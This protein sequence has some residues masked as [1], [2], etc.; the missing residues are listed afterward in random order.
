MSHFA[1]FHVLSIR[2]VALAGL[3]V[4]IAT[5]VSFADPPAQ[6]MGLGELPSG[7]FLSGATSVSADGSTVVGSS[8]VSALP[9]SPSN[10]GHAFRWQSGPMMDLGWGDCTEATGTS[11]YGDVVVGKTTLCGSAE[12]RG[13][14][15]DPNGVNHVIDIGKFT[16]LYDVSGDGVTSVGY[17]DFSISGGPTRALRMTYDA[18]GT[19]SYQNLGTLPGALSSRANGISLDGN[20]VVGSSTFP[21]ALPSAFRWTSTDGMVNL[22]PLGSSISSTAVAASSTGHS[23]VGYRR[24]ASMEREAFRWDQQSGM[25]GLG[26]LAVAPGGTP[27]SSAAAIDGPGWSIIGTTNSVNGYVAFIWDPLN[28]MRRLSTVLSSLGAN[29]TG[30]QLQGA[31]DISSDGSVIVGVGINPSGTYEAWRAVLPEPAALPLVLVMLALVRRRRPIGTAT[32]S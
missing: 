13:L 25:V 32:Y 9:P 21:S 28:G 10:V 22:D 23:I 15:R 4:G 16:E 2:F 3:L 30:W 12:A 27:F 11:S 5:A 7:T 14:Y 31:T 18:P 24:T 6:F 29:L 1:Q 8:V 26:S 19:F 20:T 17:S